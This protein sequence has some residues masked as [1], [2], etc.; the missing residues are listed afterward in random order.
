LL[1]QV[2]RVIHRA[3]IGERGEIR[4]AHVNT[5]FSV[6]FGKGLGP[7][8][9][10]ETH[11]PLSNVAFDRNRFNRS[12]NRPMQLNFDL[13]GTLDTQLSVGQQPA[14]VTV[15]GEGDT[16]VSPTGTESGESRPLA[17]LAPGVKRLKSIVQSPENVLAA[18]VVRQ[19]GQT[20]R[21]QLF[22][23]IGLIV[24]VKRDAA[25]FPGVASL[26]ERTVI[27]VASFV[28]LRSE[29][30]CLLMGGIQ[31]IFVGDAQQFPLLRS[32]LF[33]HG[34]FAY[35]PDGASIVASRPKRGNSPPK[36]P[37]FGTHIS[38]GNAFEAVHNLGNRVARVEGDKQVLV[39][40]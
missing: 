36:F 1:S 12:L 34:S 8:F 21:P 30:F 5:D 14:S 11:K 7:I 40:A 23:L 15:R 32:N 10:R 37:K 26:F 38:T 9:H 28:Q 3:A 35:L 29:E 31:A 17:A 24:V 13:P 19:P 25:G 16:V 18:R 20:L 27:Q 39:R 2:S 4:E 33:A 22:E 6:T